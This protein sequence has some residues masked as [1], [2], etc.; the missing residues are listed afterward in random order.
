MNLRPTSCEHVLARRGVAGHRQY[1]IPALAVSTRGTIL[2]AYDGRPNLDDLPSPID[3]LIRRSTDNG[4]TWGPQQAVRT[5]SGLD[6]YGDPSLLVDTATGRIFMFHAAGTHAGFFE[7]VAGLEDEDA[8]QHADLSF[9][10]DD[11]ATWEHRRLTGM[12]KR[13]GMTGLFAAAGAGIQIHT[14]AF[15]GRLV[16]QFVVLFHG[17]ILSASAYSDDHGDTWTLGELIAGGNENK[18]V[19]RTDGSLLMHSRATPF[20]LTAVSSDGGQSYSPAQPHPELPDPSDNGSV[21]RFDGLPNVT[22]LASPETEHWLIATHN[23]DSL[24]RR[25]TLLKLSQDDG[26]TWPFAVVLC[27]GSSQYSTA[28]RLPSGRIGVLYERQGYQ[29][30]VFTTVEPEELLASPAAALTHD[31]D[32]SMAGAVGLSVVLRSITPGRPAVWESVGESFVLAQTDGDWD[33]ATWKE[34][35]QDYSADMPQVLSNRESQDVNYGSVVPGY[36]AGDVLAFSGRVEDFADGAALS[37]AV[38]LGHLVDGGVPF[39]RGPAFGGASAGGAA[40]GET[41]VDWEPLDAGAVR[42]FAATYTMTE[43]DVAATSLTLVFTVGVDT[44]SSSA[45]AR[46]AFTFDVA[47]GDIGTSGASSTAG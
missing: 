24:L 25:N 16:Q 33:P 26:A 19:A 29:E 46:R 9:S 11:G 36:K 31:A 5:G 30:I 37:V 21:A 10:D 6:G 12:L 41:I 35:G 39:K 43:T 28:T 1:R 23:H 20:R 2:A 7:A 40:A 4:H 18:V 22:S 45:C 8:I 38:R 42:G 3:L 27:A 32:T 44:G 15:T 34:V 17:E 47:S 13:D 14:G